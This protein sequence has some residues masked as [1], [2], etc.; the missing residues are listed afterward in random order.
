MN[1][2]HWL[3]LVAMLLLAAFVVSCGGA[4]TV[5]DAVDSAADAAGDAVDSAADAAADAAGD[6]V[7][8]VEEVV[9]DVMDGDEAM[10]DDAMME[11]SDAIGCVE[12]AAGDPIRIASALVITG[13]NES[14]GLDSQLSL[15]HI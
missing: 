14:L 3:K 9:E 6:A 11:C 7:D 5:T 4:D 2:K 10:D 13:P 1:K 15:I 12:Y 8:S